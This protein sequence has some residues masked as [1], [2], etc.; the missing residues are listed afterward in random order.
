[1]IISGPNTSLPVAH[2]S[3]KQTVAAQH[4]GEAET[5][6][7]RDVVYQEGLPFVGILEAIFQRPIRLIAET[8]SETAIGAIKRGYSRKMA[9]LRKTQRLSLSELHEL[10]YG[11]DVC[12]DE[13]D[14]KSI[15]RLRHVPGDD[16][17][18][19]VLTKALAVEKH[20]ACAR[21]L[22]MIVVDQRYLSM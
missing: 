17:P 14:S 12:I 4:P 19:D 22:G 13:D 6:A 16:D 20:W 18:V 7:L 1:M 11:H 2:I 5:V 10:F 15:D 21:G 8:D 3:R 9:Y